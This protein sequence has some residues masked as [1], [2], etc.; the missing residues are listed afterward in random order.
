MDGRGDGGSGPAGR[1]SA[2]RWRATVARL[3]ARWRGSPITVLRRVLAAALVLVAAALAA[4]P[5]ADGQPTVT[6]VVAARDLPLGTE[7]TEGDLRVADLPG[8]A[9]PA[10]ALT[11]PSEAA[12]HRLV[13]RARQGEVLT[14]VR[15]ARRTGGPPGSAT[16]PIRLADGG[17]TTL[18]RAGTPVDVVTPGPDAGAARVVAERAT[19]VA[20]LKRSGRDGAGGPLSPK[21]D[22]LVLV[23]VP[24]DDAP[25]VAAAALDRPVT[26]TLR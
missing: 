16:V 18:L 3:R 25:R 7:L 1:W 12:G 21:D 6:V 19:V 4:A 2:A 22:P 11:A 8:Q 9:R 13:G 17:V 20:V 24:D 14:D 23:S 26:V 10:G 5:G 15:L